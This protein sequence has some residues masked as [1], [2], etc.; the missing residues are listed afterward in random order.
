MSFSRSRKAAWQAR[1]SG[2][3]FRLYSSSDEHI[4]QKSLWRE[5]SEFDLSLSIPTR[6]QRLIITDG[7][8]VDKYHI[9]ARHAEELRQ[10]IEN[11]EKYAD[12][13]PF[14]YRPQSERLPSPPPSLK[15]LSKPREIAILAIIC[16]VQILP[17]SALGTSFPTAETI[18]LSFNITSP[19]ILPW[20]VAAY[21][22]TFGTFILIAG[23]LGDILGHRPMVVTGFTI[24]SLSSLLAGLSIYSSYILYFIARALQGVGSACMQPNGLALLGSMYPANS[25]KKNLAFALFGAMAAPGAWLGMLFGALL[26]R[27]PSWAWASY[28][29]AIVATL[30]AVAAQFILVAP[31]QQQTSI[32]LL[33]R[34]RSMDWAGSLTGVMG[35]TCIAIAWVQAPSLGWSTQ[36]IYMLFLLGVFSLSSFILI[37]LRVATYPLVPFRTLKPSIAFILASVG[38]GWASFGIYIFY[39]WQ[40]LLHT[41]HLSPLSAALQISPVVPMGFLANG[42]TGLLMSRTPASL[43]L[44]ISLLAFTGAATLL[45]LTPPNQSYWSLTFASLLLVPFGMDMSF[46]AATVTIS[47][48]LPL[49]QQGIAGSLVAT[50][51]N[52]SMSL[53]LGFAATAMRYAGDGRGR[54]NSSYHTAFLVAI[55]LGSL[56]TL[57]CLVFVGR[58][59]LAGRRARGQRSGDGK[60][61]FRLQMHGRVMETPTASRM[62]LIAGRCQC[63]YAH[64]GQE[65][66][67]NTENEADGRMS[68]E[69]LWEAHPAV[70]PLALGSGGLVAR[71]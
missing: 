9:P 33:T 40:L 66:N 23:R 61:R 52:Y 36:Y 69:T 21:T 58:D 68:S 50:V 28:V 46:P 35:L 54:P 64:H 14:L 30:C 12:S 67:Q 32:P 2:D 57:C 38:L 56:G 13:T 53:G 4:S 10:R 17:L 47:N 42:L 55:A 15:A 71:I 20:T 65:Q 22:L 5:P 43:I 3:P 31:P 34:L 27:Y 48:T 70:R 1:I 18:A 11:L 62:N 60:R 26:A 24:M 51:V 39:L 16:M 49:E 63:G 41:R 44:L 7:D 6:A 37:E 29:L 19:A 59:L 8:S 25:R 45:A